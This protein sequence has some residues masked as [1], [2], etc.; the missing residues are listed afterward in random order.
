MTYQKQNKSNNLTRLTSNVKSS[1]FSSWNVELQIP[2]ATVPGSAAKGVINDATASILQTVGI[3]IIIFYIIWVLFI[4]PVGF[5]IY[6]VNYG[7]SLIWLTPISIQTLG[8]CSS[9]PRITKYVRKFC[10]MF[11]ICQLLLP[12]WHGCLC[13]HCGP[14]SVGSNI[15]FF[16]RQVM[17]LAPAPHWLERRRPMLASFTSA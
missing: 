12:L 8:Q 5:Q 16:W 2:R 6:A 11:T 14:V 17:L 3:N 7:M 1:C 9:F 4:L 15:L 10:C 13:L